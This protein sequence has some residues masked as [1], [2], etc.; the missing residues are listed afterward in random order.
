MRPPKTK[1]K[2]KNPR[3][4]RIQKDEVVERIIYILFWLDVAI[5]VGQSYLTGVQRACYHRK[6]YNDWLRATITQKL[7][8]YDWLKEKTDGILWTKPRGKPTTIPEFEMRVVV[9]RIMD[10]F[11][12]DRLEDVYIHKHRAT[13]LNNKTNANTPRSL[14]QEFFGGI[15]FRTDRPNNPW[16]A[17]H[18]RYDGARN[19][20]GDRKTSAKS[21]ATLR[22]AYDHLVAE[23]EEVKDIDEMQGVSVQP[24]SY[25]EEQFCEQFDEWI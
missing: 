11:E 22:E 10:G 2:K 18:T 16:R 8:Y 24:F 4:K 23:Y 3:K 12:A 9:T 13:V 15:D 21:F 25:Y 17:Q 5:Y 6:H 7:A 20:R 1:K 19:A 14:N